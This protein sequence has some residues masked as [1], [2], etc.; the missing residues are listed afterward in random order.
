MPVHSYLL[1]NHSCHNQIPNALPSSSSRY[2][3]AALLHCLTVTLSH[4]WKLTHTHTIWKSR[5]ASTHEFTPTCVDESQWISCFPCLSA[6][7]SQTHLRAPQK[8]LQPW[9]P[10]AYSQ[11]D[12][13]SRHWVAQSLFVFYCPLL[14]V[15]GLH[16]QGNHSTFPHFFSGDNFQDPQWMPKSVNST[17]PYVHIPMVK[18]PLNYK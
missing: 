11:R 6:D 10:V 8:T 2:E 1:P 3:S 17:K 18:F 12:Q 9:A 4:L 15:L 16:F 5:G 13:A 14:L 7:S